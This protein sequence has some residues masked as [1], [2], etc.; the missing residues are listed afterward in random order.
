MKT[1]YESV[2]SLLGTDVASDILVVHMKDETIAIGK[3]MINNVGATT[4]KID[5]IARF[6]YLENAT[7]GMYNLAICQWDELSEP[8]IVFSLDSVMSISKP[9]KE[10]LNYYNK[11][12]ANVVAKKQPSAEAE[13]LASQEQILS[14]IER[15]Q[16]DQSQLN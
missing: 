8:S 1:W 7:S 11:Y 3:I 10:A 15:L 6:K 9:K 12:M 13:T 5:D 4:L 16:I 14:Y 2:H